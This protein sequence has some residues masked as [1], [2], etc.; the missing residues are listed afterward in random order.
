MF[1]QQISKKSS[2]FLMELIIVLFFF[3]LCAAV[4]VNIFAKAKLINDKSYELNKSIV[5]A[6]N[7]AECFKAAN[8][9]IITLANLL[10]GTA[11]DNVVKI[12][13]DENWQN[14]NLINAIYMMSI[15]I[16]KNK[17]N[18][19]TAVITVFNK[20]KTLYSLTVK[21]LRKIQ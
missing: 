11:E 1:T 4:C 9:D 10:N 20:D 21:H 2:L 14:T 6:Q 19:T 13:Y 7:A 8:S 12:G 15:N 17:S 18:L 3:A 5:A 16:Q